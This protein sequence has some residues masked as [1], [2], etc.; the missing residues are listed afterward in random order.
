MIFLQISFDPNFIVKFSPSCCQ[1]LLDNFRYTHSSV[2]TCER[3]LQVWH[4]NSLV[5]ND[6]YQDK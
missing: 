6:I 1:L 3:M 5:W 4:Y 2:S